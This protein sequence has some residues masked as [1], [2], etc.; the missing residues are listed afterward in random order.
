MTTRFIL[1]VYSQDCISK[2][3]VTSDV[4]LQP[5][6]FYT[7]GSANVERCLLGSQDKVVECDVV[8]ELDGQSLTAQ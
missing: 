8:P 3:R 2:N 5:D 6:G 1:S 7:F 4:I